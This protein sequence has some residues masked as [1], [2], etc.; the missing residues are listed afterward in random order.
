[1]KTIEQLKERIAQTEEANKRYKNEIFEALKG[2]LENSENFLQNDKITELIN[3]DVFDLQRLIEMNNNYLE[4]DKAELFMLQC[5]ERLE[6]PKKY[7]A[8]ATAPTKND[9]PPF[10]NGARP[11]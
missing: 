9:I 7:I 2:A 6:N 11:F 1:M 5:K 8:I 4:K 3:Y 10:N